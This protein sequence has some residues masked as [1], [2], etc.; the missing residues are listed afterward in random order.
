MSAN[1]TVMDGYTLQNFM[2]MLTGS[3]NL[4]GSLYRL[5]IR[6]H[7]NGRVEF[8]VN[9]GGEW[10]GAMGWPDARYLYGSVSPEALRTRAEIVEERIAEIDAGVPQW[11]HSAAENAVAAVEARDITPDVQAILDEINS[12]PWDVA[13]ELERHRRLSCIDTTE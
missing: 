4:P 2:E 1:V 10:T 3:R 8:K 6:Q 11:D 7:D 13:Q 9:D 12:N 5:R